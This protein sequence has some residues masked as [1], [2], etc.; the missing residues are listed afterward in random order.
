MK[1]PTKCGHRVKAVTSHNEMNDDDRETHKKTI[2]TISI[3]TQSRGARTTATRS[4]KQPAVWAFERTNSDAGGGSLKKKSPLAD[5]GHPGE[6]PVGLEVVGI[7]SEG[8]E[9]RS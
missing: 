4:P 8:V 2:E 6:Q 1:R 9:G 5:Q 7:G 3:D